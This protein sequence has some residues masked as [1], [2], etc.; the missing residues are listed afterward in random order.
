MRPSATAQQR[1]CSPAASAAC[2]T[3]ILKS[4]HSQ[5]T[6]KGLTSYH[7]GSLKW[8]FLFFQY[9]QSWEFD[10]ADISLERNSC[11][12]GNIIHSPLCLFNSSEPVPWKSCTIETG[13][14]YSL[15]SIIFNFRT[16]EHK[17]FLGNICFCREAC[18]LTLCLV[19]SI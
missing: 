7:S 11:T 4:Y 1:L 5:G 8:L 10:F 17:I 9:L 12:K 6:I 13:K 18:K 16:K 2:G 14:S 3:L 19:T 15:M